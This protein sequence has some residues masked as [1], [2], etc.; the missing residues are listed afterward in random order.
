VVHT[1]RNLSALPAWDPIIVWYAKG[2]A[3]MQS[4][5]PDDPRSWDWQAAVHGSDTTTQFLNQCQHGSWYFAP[6][7]RGYLAAFEAIVRNAITGLGG[8]ASWALPYWDMSKPAWRLIRSEFRAQKLPDGSD[9][10]L[11]VPQRRPGWKTGDV[12]IAAWGVALDS[13]LL[14][15][16]FAGSGGGGS[17]GFGGPVTGFFHG[18]GAGGALEAGIHNYVHSRVSGF[19]GDFNTA[20]LDPLFWLH[21]CNIDRLWEVWRKRDP[22]HKD[23]AQTSWKSGPTTKKFKVYGA[24]GAVWTFT[25]QQLVDT[26]APQLDYVYEDVS[27]P[28]AGAAMPPHLT[29][30]LAARARAPRGRLGIT[31]GGG[32][33]MLQVLGAS[34]RKVRLTAGRKSASISVKRP[35]R[36]AGMKSFAAGAGKKGPE[37]ILLNLENITGV[38]PGQTYRVFVN[39]P[40]DGDPDTDEHHLVGTVSLFGVNTASDPDGE[41]AGNGLSYVFD[42]TPFAADLKDDEAKDIKVDFVADDGERD[43]DATVGRISIVRETP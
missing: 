4:R 8:P 29:G 18:P 12:G 20:G 23:P 21:H 36:P 37:R 11:Y 3:E 7:H 30:F 28:L 32:R 25:P 2:I 9:N 40:D 22:A 14:E 33:P 34:A 13:I 31:A 27:D 39:L 1:R 35:K 42:I 5:D 6:W 24:T 17:T 41:H 10:P 26:K 19:M 43:D 15:P 38:D 16:F